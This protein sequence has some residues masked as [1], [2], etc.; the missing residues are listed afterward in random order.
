VLPILKR[1]LRFFVDTIQ[2]VT[3]LLSLLGIV[4]CLLLFFWYVYQEEVL[5]CFVCALGVVTCIYLNKSL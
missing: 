4:A 1:L 5:M 3:L 2:K